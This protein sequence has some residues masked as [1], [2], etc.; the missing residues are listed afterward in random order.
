MI[1]I[2]GHEGSDEYEAAIALKEAFTKM[3]PGCESSPLGQDD[4]RIAA[5]QQSPATTLSLI[6]I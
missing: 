3:W 5:A 2:I 4:V 6:H 1:E